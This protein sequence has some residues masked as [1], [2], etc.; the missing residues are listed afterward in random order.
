MEEPEGLEKVRIIPP[1]LLVDVHSATSHPSHHP[2]RSAVTP[3]N[4]RHLAFRTHCVLPPPPH[5]FASQSTNPYH[6]TLPPPLAFSSP[7][8]PL[9]PLANENPRL[10]KVAGAQP[11]YPSTLAT[12]FAMSID[13]HNDVARLNGRWAV[14]SARVVHT[15][16]CAE[17]LARTGACPPSW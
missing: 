10:E 7:P 13:M 6:V 16:G 2:T 9:Y 11:T 3:V 15:N 14:V 12:A 5:A 1:S 8:L 4:C 17:G